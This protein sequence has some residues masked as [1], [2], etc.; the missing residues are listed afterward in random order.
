VVKGP[1]WDSSQDIHEDD[2]NELSE[3][4]PND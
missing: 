3:E 1:S 2:E 4:D